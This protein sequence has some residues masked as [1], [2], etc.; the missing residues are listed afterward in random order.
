[1]TLVIVLFLPFPLFHDCSS[2]FLISTSGLPSERNSFK[3]SGRAGCLAKRPSHKC[4]VKQRKLI[5]YVRMESILR[6][7]FVGFDSFPAF[8]FHVREQL[9]RGKRNSDAL[10]RRSLVLKFLKT[11][12]SEKHLSFVFSLSLSTFGN[13]P[14]RH[15]YQ[16][17]LTSSY[18]LKP[19]SVNFLFEKKRK[20]RLE[21]KGRYQKRFSKYQKNKRN[22]WPRKASLRVSGLKDAEGE[23]K[24]PVILS[25]D[26]SRSQAS[27]YDGGQT[28]R[29]Q[30]C[31]VN[32]YDLSGNPPARVLRPDTLPGAGAG[33]RLFIKIE[34]TRGR[35][36][37]MRGE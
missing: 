20:S 33:H 14:E 26:V 23:S 9:Q 10:V 29:D 1:M 25:G 36:R 27:Q 34:E 19:T 32:Y 3:T 2:C 8:L 11:Y 18:F 4:H 35:H 12:F 13:F 6:N 28:V 30:T 17:F 22:R 24:S 21:E 15:L 5:L 7:L 31:P 37:M 16:D